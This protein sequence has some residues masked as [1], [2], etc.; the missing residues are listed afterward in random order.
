[1]LADPIDVGVRFS[2][3]CYALEPFIGQTILVK[4]GRSIAFEPITKD[5]VILTQST[6]W[7]I[8]GGYSYYIHPNRPCPKEEFFN[9][10]QVA[11]PD[12]F[13]WLLFH[14]E[15]FCPIGLKQ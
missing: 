1:M 7:A 14:P 2:S 8:V 3:Y 11:H 5:C 13:E 9:W 12:S 15:W 10:I 6:K 4:T